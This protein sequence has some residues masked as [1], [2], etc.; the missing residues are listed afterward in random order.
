MLNMSKRFDLSNFKT[1]ESITILSDP[2]HN[3][4]IKTGETFKVDQF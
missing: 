1:V 3:L 4:R 2:P